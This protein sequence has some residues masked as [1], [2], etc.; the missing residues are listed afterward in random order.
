M[1]SP[2][3]WI[4]PP[5]IGAFIGYVTNLVAI[6][7]LFRPLQA[8]HIFGIHLPFTPGILP[9]ERGKLAENIGDMVE[10]ELLTAGVLRERLAKPKVRENIQ[11]AISAYTDTL[12]SRPLSYWLSED[13]SPLPVSGL[14]KDFVNSEVFNSFLEEVIK[15]WAAK[16]MP[17]S[18][19]S[20]DPFSLWL[21]SRA[22]D[23][24]SIFIPAARDIIKSSIFSEIKKSH[25]G[26][27][28]LYKQSLENIVKKYPGITLREFLSMSNAKKDETDSFLAH[29]TQKTL[30]DNIEHALA[31]VNIKALVSD[32]INSLDM[33]KVEKIVLGVMAGQLKWINFFGAVLGALIGF[34]QV[35]LSLLTG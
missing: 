32:R 34:S 24:S 13:R 8:V 6:K 3:F 4:L 17:S 26:E 20:D 1:T 27:V 22:R 29:K 31:S 5:L 21:K 7:M 9:K 25:P 14:L 35:I 30:N 16:K 23:V 33:I 2:L 28:S 18:R 15:E 11:T 19:S 10:R 12:V